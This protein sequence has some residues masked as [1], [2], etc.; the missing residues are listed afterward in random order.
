MIVGVSLSGMPFVA[1]LS[2]RVCLD[3]Y[4]LL[5]PNN[6]K[7]MP[8]G[9]RI[10]YRLSDETPSPIHSSD[11]EETWQNKTLFRDRQVRNMLNVLETRRL[12]PPELSQCENVMLNIASFLA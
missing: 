1:F 8:N 2:N 6:G 4:T 12:T 5:Q 10:P 11:S 7:P 9:H 3:S